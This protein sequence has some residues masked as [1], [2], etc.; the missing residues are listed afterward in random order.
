[1]SIRNDHW[2]L[3][4]T[5]SSGLNIKF[6]TDIRPAISTENDYALAKNK[7][8]IN[9]VTLLGNKTN[10]ELNIDAISNK[11]IENILNKL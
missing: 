4:F 11:E 5:D 7:P 9:G 10:E 2:K 1:M 8:S 3:K 6:G